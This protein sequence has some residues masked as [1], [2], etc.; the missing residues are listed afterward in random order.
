MLLLL[1]FE[2]L[3]GEAICVAA[4]AQ[5]VLGKVLDREKTGRS[6][7]RGRG[8]TGANEGGSRGCLVG[9]GGLAASSM[10]YEVL[11]AE[12]SPA[13]PGHLNCALGD[14]VEFGHCQG[15]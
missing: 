3:L 8:W 15:P 9:S 7:E 5:D 4:A 10:G 14:Q 2:T 12:G 1:L 11:W 13:T 6:L